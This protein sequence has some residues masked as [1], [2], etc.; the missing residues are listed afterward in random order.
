MQDRFEQMRTFVA[1]AQTKR[2][3]AAADRLGLVR[4]AVSRRLQ[5]IEERLGVQLVTRNTRNLSL[6]DAGQEYYSRALAILEDVDAAEANLSKVG[7][8]ATGR[9]RISAPV[10][11]SVMHLAPLAAE[12]SE[13]F[14]GLE[15]D[16]N[17]NDRV[18]DVVEEGFDVALRIS[19]LKDSTLV[20]REIAPI[21]HVVCASPAY[22]RR[23]GKPKRPDD[24]RIHRGLNYA[25]VDDRLCWQFQ[26][27]GTQELFS[28]DVPVLARVNNGDALREMAM[29]GA[30][31]AILPTFIVCHAVEAGHLQ[32]VL[33]EFIRPPL[34][35][36][37]I[38]PSR[39]HL[40][41]KVRVFV[42]FLLEKYG[43]YPVWDRIAGL[44]PNLPSKS[45]PA[46]IVKK[47]KSR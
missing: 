39:R 5:E 47:A 29:A 46:K 44:Q 27:P 16:I 12:F 38:Y 28:V 19:R 42:D 35:L 7:S 8:D 3:G 15:L 43:D 6:T 34:H 10:S 20:A 37:A 2:L 18:V 14:P 25:N 24:L 41:A 33:T 30:G 36:Y 40:S 9:L 23:R 32:T 13:R 26:D 17:L 11:W 31:V 4:S 1:I 21:R 22:F 45:Q